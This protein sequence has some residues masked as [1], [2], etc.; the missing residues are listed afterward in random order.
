MGLVGVIGG[1]PLLFVKPKLVVGWAEPL[2]LGLGMELTRQLHSPV[3][4]LVDVHRVKSKVTPDEI[5]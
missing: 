3:Y 2:H 1:L 5:S 4:A